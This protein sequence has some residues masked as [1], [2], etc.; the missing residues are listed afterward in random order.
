MLRDLRICWRKGEVTL[1]MDSIR[2][3]CV[4]SDTHVNSRNAS[5]FELLFVARDFRPLAACA[6]HSLASV[7]CL[8][9]TL[10]PGPS[11]AACRF[12]CIGN[13]YS[14]AALAVSP[15]PARELARRQSRSRAI[16]GRIPASSWKLRRTATI[17]FALM[18]GA[19]TRICG[20]TIG[21]TGLTH[22]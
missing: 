10:P 2:Q 14:T 6:V 13:S 21:R 11:L 4:C 7:R 18:A 20:G 1:A 16:P 3:S 17:P 19:G 8:A 15:N 12:T 22:W 5:R 9:D